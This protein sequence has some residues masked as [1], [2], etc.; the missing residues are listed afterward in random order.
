MTA[1]MRKSGLAGDFLSHPARTAG[2]STAFTG[3]PVLGVSVGDLLGE[4]INPACAAASGYWRRSPRR[5]RSSSK[6]TP[7]TMARQN[8]AAPSKN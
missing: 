5:Y 1:V 4:P 2:A 6:N 3:L 7:Q 8:C